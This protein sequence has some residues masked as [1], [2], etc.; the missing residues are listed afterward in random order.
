MAM[1]NARIDDDLKA[2][3]DAVLQ[4]RNN[5]VTQ[6]I[7]DLYNYIDQHGQSPF[8]APHVHIPPTVLPQNAV[9]IC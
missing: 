3:V 5:T 6:N 4:S 9:P 7:T 8:M 1:V 2:R